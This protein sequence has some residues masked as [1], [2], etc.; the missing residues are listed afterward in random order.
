MHRP[1]VSSCCVRSDPEGLARSRSALSAAA[2]RA[3]ARPGA[4]RRDDLRTSRARRERSLARWS[5]S[6]AA[7]GVS[8]C[9]MSSFPTAYAT[10]WCQS[11]FSHRHEIFVAGRCVGEAS[12][13]E[14][15]D[16]R[17][18]SALRRVAVPA[19]LPRS[20]TGGRSCRQL[21]SGGC[22]V[23]A[24]HPADGA[25]RY[26]WQSF[27]YG[28]PGA[29]VPQ[30]ALVRPPGTSPQISSRN[31]LKLRHNRSPGKSRTVPS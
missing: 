3:T 23:P 18:W 12:R 24:S 14:V 19:V 1:G 13:V 9:R 28:R 20:V 5:S 25:R 29:Y 6:Q 4:S 2:V 10:V 27:S 30:T 11:L 17:A 8:G 15:R 26:W 16:R 7:D 22:H 31:A 21:R